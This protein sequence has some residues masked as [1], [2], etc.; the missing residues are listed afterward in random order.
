[1]LE[2]TEQR[3]V[4][5][6][7]EAKWEALKKDISDYN[8]HSLG[9]GTAE[10]ALNVFLEVLWLHLV[11]HIPRRPLQIVKRSH[12][13]MNDRSRAA[14]AEKNRAEGTPA[15]SDASSK[16]AAILT[17]ER[18]KQVEKVKEKMAS[19]PSASKSWWKINRELLRRKATL[20][21]IQTL[22]E[23]GK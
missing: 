21:S 15:F 4:W 1:M 12:P 22:R 9:D 18:L 13:W 23:D 5:I 8:W 3:D 7:K 20:S 19:L 11:K 10:D 17:E 6:L 14:I 2:Q 16:C